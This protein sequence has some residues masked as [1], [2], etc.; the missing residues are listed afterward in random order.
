MQD[1]VEQ[2][3]FSEIHEKRYTLAGKA[4]ICNGVLFEQFRYTANTPA[5]K[6]V[7]DGTYQ[8]PANLDTAT[9]ELFDKIAAIC[10]LLPA[11][12]ISIVITPEQWKQYWK[13][14]NDE[15]LSSESGIHFGNYIVGSKFDI[16]SHYH[17]A[18]V[19]VTLAHA[20]QLE[21]WSRGLLVMLEK[22]LGVTLVTKLHA[23]L[24]MEGDFN[25]AN[26]MVHSMRM[27]NNARDHNLMPEE[28]FSKKNRMADDGTL[29]KTL[30]Y[31]ITRQARVP[32]ANALVDA[33]NCYSRIA[34]AMASMIF[35][36][37]GVP[38]TAIES[39]LG[40]IK[41]MKFF[42]RTGFSDPASFAGGGISIKTQ[43][44]CQGNGAPPAGWAVISICILWAHG[45][46][47]YGAKFLCPITRL[48]QH[49]S[50]IL[51]VDDTDILHI[52]LTKDESINNV[53]V[54][55]QDSMNSWGNLLITTGGVLQPNECFYSIISF[56]WLNRD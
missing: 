53:H 9:I 32:A 36:T 18:Q 49:L 33:S 8:V 16:I 54:A 47:G 48:Q 30:F 43:G 20:I 28:I 2:T 19:S 17:T 52:N 45:K 4:P 1:K 27:L 34:H 7:L 25:A 42:L 56:E 11:S 51:Y 29:C 50:V 35:Q 24:V 37:V 40:A 5:S 46:K 39:M 41:N 55:I 3:I 38:T 31:N 44:L 10:R 6:V 13:I 14:V 21:R 23:I 22:T 15:T 12:S 26:K